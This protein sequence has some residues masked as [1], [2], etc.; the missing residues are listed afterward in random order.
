MR[1]IPDIYM[2]GGHWYELT[3]SLKS[4]FFE[5]CNIY[6]ID[7]GSEMALVD[8]GYGY[9]VDQVI[10]NIKYER[11]D[12]D[13]LSKVIITHAHI[14]HS[15]G[16]KAFQEKFGLKIICHTKCA[17]ALRTADIHTLAYASVE[18]EFPICE[19]DLIVEDGDEIQV[20]NK[21]LKVIY[22]PGHS[23]DSICLYLEH[24]EKNILLSGDVLFRGGSVGWKGCIEYDPDL[25]V[26][27]LEKLYK[28]KIDVLLPAH[29]AFAVNRGH[30]WIGVSLFKFLTELHGGGPLEYLF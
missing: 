20:G 8:A 12:P 30:Y 9:S 6:L 5:D 25:L 22:T 2:V 21:T 29:E 28:M 1:I 15:R 4:K 7:G 16:A 17:E 14:D 24:E 26:K 27:T 10:D 23:F 13:K 11:L 18:D 19:A 3:L